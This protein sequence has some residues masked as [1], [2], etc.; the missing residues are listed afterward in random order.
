MHSCTRTLKSEVLDAVAKD[1][2]VFGRETA[3]LLHE[4]AAE[5]SHIGI[6]A[7]IGD[8]GES[9]IRIPHQETGLGDPV[10]IDIL[11]EIHLHLFGKE[12]GKDVNL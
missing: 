7:G 9:V 4:G 8:H 1:D 2:H 6:A 12:M 11:A 10:G 5:G 3:Y